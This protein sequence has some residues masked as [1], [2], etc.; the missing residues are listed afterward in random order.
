VAFSILGQ[1]QGTFVI[2]AL[3][4]PRQDF[5]PAPRKLQ[6]LVGSFLRLAPKNLLTEGASL[7]APQT[8]IKSKADKSIVLT[9]GKHHMKKSGD[10]SFKS[11]EI[12]TK[13]S[14]YLSL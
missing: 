9:L 4:Q 1:E 10:P 7:Y 3:D 2:A 11:D 13:E 8:Q 6:E 14:I 5:T 12:S